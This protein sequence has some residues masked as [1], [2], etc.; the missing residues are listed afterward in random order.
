MGKFEDV[1]RELTAAAPESAGSQVHELDVHL[2]PL[3]GLLHDVALLAL[4]RERVH[5]CGGHNAGGMR[6]M[7]PKVTLKILSRTPLWHHYFLIPHL[8][9]CILPRL[10]LCI[11]YM[12]SCTA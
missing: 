1:G 8:S 9:L 12:T 3:D 5:L 10:S 4:H 11:L 2:E 7:P 6:G